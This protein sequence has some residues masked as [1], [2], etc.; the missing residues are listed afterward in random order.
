M[1]LS[2]P[3]HVVRVVLPAID[4]DGLLDTASEQIRH[5]GVTDIAVSARLLRAFDDIAASTEDQGVRA[6][7]MARARRVCD[8]CRE[9]LPE[10]DLE[11]LRRRM[12]ALQHRA[13]SAGL[14]S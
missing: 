13:T 3:P 7:L 8:G 9:R 5:Y 1:L 11:T 12:D 14:G 6:S 4:L 2:D 10:A